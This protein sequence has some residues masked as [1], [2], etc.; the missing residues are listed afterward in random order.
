MRRT[1]VP[2]RTGAPA[3]PTAVPPRRGRLAF[4]DMTDDVVEPH[5]AACEH[6][7]RELTA[8][9]LWGVAGRQ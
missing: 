8:D 4:L 7:G 1:G 3:R 9:E 5:L 6:A 2:A